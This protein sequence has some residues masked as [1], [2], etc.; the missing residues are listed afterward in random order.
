MSLFNDRKLRM[1][2]GDW[3]ACVRRPLSKL[4]LET[5]SATRVLCPRVRCHER[6]LGEAVL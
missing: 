4:N 6:P 5:P 3:K 1:G 2:V